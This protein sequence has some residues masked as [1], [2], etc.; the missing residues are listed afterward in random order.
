M[1]RGVSKKRNR[2]PPF[3]TPLYVS[4]KN[5]KPNFFLVTTNIETKTFYS[6][7]QIYLIS[8]RN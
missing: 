1:V 8:N 6:E 3:A 5:S 4:Q 2:T 7:Y